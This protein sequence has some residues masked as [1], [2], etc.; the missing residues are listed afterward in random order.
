MEQRVEALLFDLGRV[1][2]DIEPARTPARW[3]EL[4]G[5]PAAALAAQLRL[6]IS[7]G[8]AYCRHERGEISDQAF[9]AHVRGELA[10]ELTDA[11]FEDGWNAIFI[12][13]MPGIRRLLASVSGRLALYAFSNTN[14]AHRAHWSQ[15]FADLL[16]PF[17]KVYVSHEIGAR[18]PEAAA[19]RTVVAD[20]GVAPERVLFFDDSA[21]NV[22]G[23]RAC[24][25]RAVK[26]DGPSDVERALEE[27]W[28]DL[29]PN[30]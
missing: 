29:P 21:E 15:R 13:E 3:A 26:V 6:R 12:G 7:G 27:L 5:I 10:L 18:K 19:F 28:A 2:I 11:Q 25:L 30:L 24:G 16:A 4:A 23:A 14:P 22:A 20:I 8:D 1:V 9:F 17:Q